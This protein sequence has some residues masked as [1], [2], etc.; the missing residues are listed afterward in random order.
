MR[1]E[2]FMTSLPSSRIKLVFCTQLEIPRYALLINYYT[3]IVWVKSGMRTMEPL[4]CSFE[5]GAFHEFQNTSQLFWMFQI[6][7]TMY[8]NKV[9][10]YRLKLQ[11]SEKCILLIRY[12]LEDMGN[13]ILIYLVKQSTQSKC[14]VVYLFK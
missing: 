4:Q 14:K 2:E 6:Q 1:F 7:N 5:L 3:G 13:H 9:H 11:F 10:T 8:Y 12:S